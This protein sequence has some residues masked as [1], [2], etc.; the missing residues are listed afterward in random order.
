MTRRCSVIFKPL[1]RQIRSIRDGV[2]MIQ[3]RCIKKTNACRA[4]RAMI[5][6]DAVGLLYRPRRASRHPAGSTSFG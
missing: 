4:Q 5:D 2:L 1:S 3:T 6:A